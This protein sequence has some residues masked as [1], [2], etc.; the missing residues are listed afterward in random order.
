MATYNL[1]GRVENRGGK[2]KLIKREEPVYVPL[3]G[4][5]PEGKGEKGRLYFGEKRNPL[6]TRNYKR[7][8]DKTVKKPLDLNTL[9]KPSNIRSF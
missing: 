3:K 8:P 2:R 6:K 9:F 4:D 5:G 7:K 1:P